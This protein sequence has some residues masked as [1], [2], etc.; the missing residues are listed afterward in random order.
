MCG[1]ERIQF[2]LL[3]RAYEL[4]KSNMSDIFFC[5]QTSCGMQPNEGISLQ[6]ALPVSV[7][8]CIHCLDRQKF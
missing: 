1:H 7:F 5:F 8:E 6:G 3:I 4:I 2:A